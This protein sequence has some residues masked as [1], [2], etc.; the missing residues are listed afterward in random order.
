M[1][2]DAAKLDAFMGRFVQDMGAVAHAATVLLGDRLGLYKAM[3]DGAPVT[4][5]DLAQRTGCDERSLREWLAAQAASGY[6]QYDPATTTF[7]LPEE[8]AFTLT[9]EDNPVFV[10]GGFQVA[11]SM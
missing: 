8:Q 5:G 4:P 6:V 1:S 11:R 10:P 3:S 2:I 9:R 7:R